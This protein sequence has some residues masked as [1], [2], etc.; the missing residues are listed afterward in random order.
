[1]SMLAFEE[2]FERDR[3]GELSGAD[4]V[5]R[6]LIDLLMDRLEEVRRSRKSET[7]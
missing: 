4:Q 5:T 6:E 1:M 7:R 2:R 3:G